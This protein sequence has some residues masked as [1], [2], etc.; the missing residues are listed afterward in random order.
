MHNMPD[1]Y[2][3]VTQFSR[4]DPEF[5]PLSPDNCPPKTELKF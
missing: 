5:M 2:E 4:L 3:S 1:K